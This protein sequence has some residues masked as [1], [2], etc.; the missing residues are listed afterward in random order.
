M[1]TLPRGVL[2]VLQ[3][4][5][6]D[7]ESIDFDRLGQ[8]CEFVL[9]EGGDGVVFALASEM[10]RLSDTERRDV[11]G[12]IG[13]ITRGKTPFVAGVGAESTRTAVSHARHAEESGATAVMATPPLCTSA[14]ESELERYYE[15][16][17][18]SVAIPVVVQDASSY[19]G[20]PLPISLQLRLIDRYG[21]SRV[22]FKPESAPVGP[23]VDTLRAAGGPDLAIYEG[24]GGAQVAANYARGLT[25]SIPGSEMVRSVVALWSALEAGNTAHADRIAPWIA[26]LVACGVGLDGYLAIEKHL[27]VRQGV[28]VNEI[29]RGPVGFRLDSALRAH[30][31]HLYDNLVRAT[32]T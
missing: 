3:M 11:V 5:Y 16:L 30:V 4:P 25:G 14:P 2:P 12:L 9:G 6:H 21:P 27:L 32:A 7:D 26:S 1:T 17:L 13:N 22:S 8:L 28:F 18:D 15:S 19:V 23:V 10:L 29:V 31:D 24:D 20:S